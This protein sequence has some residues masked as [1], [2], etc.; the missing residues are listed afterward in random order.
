MKTDTIRDLVVCMIALTI[1]AKGKK[2]ACE[3]KIHYTPYQLT[4]KIAY[5]F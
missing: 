1:L 2:I 4:D 3:Y 5:P